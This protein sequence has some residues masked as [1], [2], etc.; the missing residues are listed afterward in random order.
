M[1]NG[2]LLEFA[3]NRTKPDHVY[4]ILSEFFSNFSIWVEIVQNLSASRKRNKEKVENVL[5]P[6]EPKTQIQN[7]PPSLR[8][9]RYLSV[10]PQPIKSPH[11]PLSLSLSLNSL[12]HPHTFS[13][14]LSLCLKN[15]SAMAFGERMLLLLSSTATSDSSV[16]MCNDQATLVP[17]EVLS[18]HS[19]VNR[20]S[21]SPI[22][23]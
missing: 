14:S 15:P 2:L 22:C 20:T 11:H 5:S 9:T 13:L 4:C 23:R 21:F 12:F 6:A 10:D 16:G 3:R 17:K 1:S 7:P 8:P 19:S 18:D